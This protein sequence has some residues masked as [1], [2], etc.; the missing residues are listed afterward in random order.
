[1][2]G[3]GIVVFATP[4]GG[5]A[6]AISKFCYTGSLPPE[7]SGLESKF[8]E[9]RELNEKAALRARQRRGSL[10]SGTFDGQTSSK[11][12]NAAEGTE[13]RFP[14]FA[15]VLKRGRDDTATELLDAIM[16][17]IGSARAKV[18]AAVEW[19]DGVRLSQIFTTMVPAWLADRPDIL[20]EATQL[21]LTRERVEC[22]KVLVDLAAPVKDL[23]LLALYDKLY[24][25]DDPPRYPMFV[26]RPMPTEVRAELEENRSR[27]DSSPSSAAAITAARSF[28]LVSG[29]LET[30]ALP[31]AAALPAPVYKKTFRTKSKETPVAPS[32]APSAAPVAA[33]VA[34]DANG[35]CDTERLS[36]GYDQLTDEPMEE[37]VYQF[38]PREVWATLDGVVPGLCAYWRDVLAKKEEGSGGDGDA[39]DLASGGKVGARWIDIYVW[40]VLLG[41]TELATLLLPACQEPMRAAVLGAR[42]FDYMANAMP[43]NAVQLRASAETQEEWAIGL[44]DLCDNF[45]EARRML[46]TL[47]HLLSPSLTFSHL[48]SPSAYPLS[49][50]PDAHHAIEPVAAD[51]PPPGP[52]IG[53]AQLLRAP[54][55]PDALRRVAAWQ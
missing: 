28:D 18:R 46:I 35:A 50:T 17:Q 24:D 55:L 38:Y 21:A 37:E 54:P 42:I 32:P 15:F 51:S 2:A 45:Q 27:R 39:E 31:A 19:D 9:L 36:N 44:L 34:A 16:G 40:A 7:W 6:E 14:L 10:L 22:I 49:G 53:A 26:G 13:A 43:L 1:M 20:R 3:N 11:I 5:L 25:A 4:T 47:S 52:P 41:N 48:L 29:A 12:F 30:E 33:V 23:D 8:D